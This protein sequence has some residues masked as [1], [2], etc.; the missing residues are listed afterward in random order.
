MSQMLNGN[1]ELVTPGRY[2]IVYNSPV[3]GTGLIEISKDHG[4]TY[5]TLKDGVFTTSSD[6]LAYL[7]GG[8][9]KFTLTGDAR[10]WLDKLPN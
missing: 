10:I 1:I 2:Q 5:Q 9:Y 7:G 6:K 3:S 8:K 4:V